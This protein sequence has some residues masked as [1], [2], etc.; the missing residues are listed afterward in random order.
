MKAIKNFILL[1]ALSFSVIA[2]SQEKEKKVEKKKD[3]KISILVKDSKNKPVAGAIILLDDVKQ[4]RRTN[5]RGYFKVKLDKAPK[6]I[7]A[8]SQKVGL[9]K[10]KYNGKDKMVITI[11]NSAQRLVKTDYKKK[12]L[13]IKQNKEKS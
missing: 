10:A 2:F 4:K 9:K 13:I 5:S 3:V 1:L 8:F 6:V 7:S 11:D 12:D